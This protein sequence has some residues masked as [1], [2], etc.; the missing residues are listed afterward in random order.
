MTIPTRSDLT[1]LTRALAVA[2]A[3][4]IAAPAP[5]SA[6]PVL[7]QIRP[8]IGD[9]LRI[10]M[11]QTV[12]MSGTSRSG[13]VD[14]VHTMFTSMA[15]YTRAVARSNVA[16]GTVMLGIADSVTIHARDSRWPAPSNTTR[17]LGGQKVEMR[18]GTDGAI[19][20]LSGSE[21][22][23]LR[24]FF[25]EMP[26][27]LPRT[28]VRIGA[29][30]SRE[31]MVPLSGDRHTQ[32]RIRASFTLD[33]LGRNGDIAYI[34]MRGTLSH[35]GS[36][37]QRP[38]DATGQITGAMQL[39]RRL[40]WITESRALVTLRSLVMRPAAG[41][42]ASSPQDTGRAPMTVETRITQWMKAAPAR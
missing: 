27:T 15:V 5:A 9:T 25:A 26:A 16:G 37:A 41:R 30:W 40:G 6:Q 23:E 39:N 34:S 14:T 4:C 22:D 31:M 32:G 17:L 19:E 38:Q 35:E 11:N 3:A 28:P 7:L 24:A 13:G 29:R 12:E 33:S 2:A 21:S 18:I 20:M 1:R 42:K 8:H 36:S 10:R